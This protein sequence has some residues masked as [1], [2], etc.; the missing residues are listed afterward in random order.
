MITIAEI[1]YSY[2]K[3][4]QRFVGK[5]IFMFSSIKVENDKHKF[6]SRI[7]ILSRD[8]MFIFDCNSICKRCIEY[9]NICSI[10][11]FENIYG[12]KN[13]PSGRDIIFEFTFPHESILFKQRIIDI[14]NLFNKKE[15]P[16]QA[17]NEMKAMQN[18]NIYKSKDY[19][20][21][22][23]EIPLVTMVNDINSS[24]KIEHDL[25]ETEQIGN[26]KIDLFIPNINS[27]NKFD[28][29]DNKIMDTIK[30]MYNENE[31]IINDIKNINSTSVDPNKIEKIV[32]QLTNQ[33]GVLNILIQKNNDSA[34]VDSLKLETHSF[35]KKL[36]ESEI[37]N[38]PV[39]DESANLYSHTNSLSSSKTKINVDMDQN[40]LDSQNQQNTLNKLIKQKTPIHLENQIE[41]INNNSSNILSSQEYENKLI[42]NKSPLHNNYNNDLN[43]SFDTNSPKHYIN[44]LYLYMNQITQ[45]IKNKYY[46]YNHI[47]N[48]TNKSDNELSYDYISYNAYS[49]EN[50]KQSLNTNNL[51]KYRF[52][53][54]K[55]NDNMNSRIRLKNLEIKELKDAIIKMTE[56]SNQIVKKLGI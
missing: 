1:P 45:P 51:N 11:L 44:D 42:R 46:K 41:T 24:S 16:F 53:D 29:N 23:I 27:A 12:I 35:E 36:S 4:F 34:I 52:K 9:K 6:K 33:N 15:V 40:I 50:S 19:I 30:N 49:Y 39:L 47:L 48:K 21:K 7:L 17:L 5:E 37:Q 22:E 26:D 2:K 25:N 8:A 43:N 31:I 10:L 55:L 18:L 14:F 38:K 56:N 28:N 13:I 32:S 3:V 20:L 54:I